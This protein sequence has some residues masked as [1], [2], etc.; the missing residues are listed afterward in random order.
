R[1]QANPNDFGDLPVTVPDDLIGRATDLLASG[2]TVMWC[3]GRAEFGPRGLCQ[4]SILADPR[5]AEM[6]ERVNSIKNRETWR[7]FAPVVLAEYAQDI[8]GPIDP[9]L[10]GRSMI[11]SFDVQPSWRESLAAVL[12]QADGTAR[13]QILSADDNPTVHRLISRFHAISGVPALLN[14]SCNDRGEPLIDSAANAIALWRKS[15]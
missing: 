7:P 13:V 15:P 12:H 4:R 14:T 5:R 10:N 3:E 1:I 8:L 11:E 6:I 9:T 2:K